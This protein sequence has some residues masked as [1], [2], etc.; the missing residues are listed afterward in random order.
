MKKKL[1]EELVRI[2]ELMGVKPRLEL[3]VESPKPIGDL[4]LNLWRK[5]KDDVDVADVD[6]RRGGTPKINGKNVTEVN[7]R[8]LETTLRDLKTRID[9]LTNTETA[10]D[11][12]LNALSQENKDLIS[13]ILR[14]DK[15]FVAEVYNKLMKQRIDNV[16]ET[17]RQYIEQGINHR[18]GPK[19][20]QPYDENDLIYSEEDLIERI[21]ATMDSS[22]RTLRQTLQQ[23]GFDSVT[24]DVLEDAITPKLD[25]FRKGAMED[26]RKL[27]NGNFTLNELGN[28]AGQEFNPDLWQI[29][30]DNFRLANIDAD[31]MEELIKTVDQNFTDKFLGNLENMQERAASMRLLFQQLNDL[32]TKNIT[33]SDNELIQNI[34]KA[35]NSQLKYF[36]ENETELF[37]NIKNFLNEAANS[38]KIDKNSP[39]KKLVDELNKNVTN[40]GKIWAFSLVDDKVRT[41]LK[42][43]K[44][45]FTSIDW[46]QVAK[47]PLKV[48]TYLPIRAGEGIIRKIFKTTK[49]EWIEKYQKFLADS[50]YTKNPEANRWADLLGNNPMGGKNTK[51]AVVGGYRVGLLGNL[52]DNSKLPYWGEKYFSG[53]GAAKYAQLEFVSR[54]VAK[55]LRLK[56]QFMFVDAFFG[57]LN[58][59]WNGDEAELCGNKILELAEKN[60]IKLDPNMDFSEILFSGELSG[61]GIYDTAECKAIES[62]FELYALKVL[63][64]D[65]ENYTP[66]TNTFTNSFLRNVPNT[67]GEAFK[68]A[69]LLYVFPGLADDIAIKVSGFWNDTVTKRNGLRNLFNGVKQ[70]LEKLNKQSKDAA[71]EVER[72]VEKVAEENP[73]LRIDLDRN[74]DRDSTSTN[75]ETTDKV[76]DETEQGFKN[77]LSSLNP[78]KT[79][80]EWEKQGDDYPNSGLPAYGKATD[81]TEYEFKDGNWQ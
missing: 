26:F 64:S 5:I 47:L 39:L 76:I 14:K 1:N 3:L 42:A 2:S 51:S 66:L 67:W 40:E 68:D 43:I 32:N 57:M 25:S 44:D 60:N 11:D 29:D 41:A 62:A 4:L 6:V 45:G 23:Y 18:S 34:Y 55:Y 16:N 17:I 77:Y 7:Y 33:S 36:Y 24:V 81:N 28:K 79:F 69:M 8:Q 21:S 54:S 73:D 22:N 58:V 71:K 20:G 49:P 52:I 48:F 72:S 46:D 37:N 63:G 78:P 38:G 74:R 70:D 35:F 12:F 19:R 15:V 30:W 80:K 75:T 10:W 9:S 27:V 61:T 65:K 59:F 53:S 13:S 56:L 31:E 50:Y